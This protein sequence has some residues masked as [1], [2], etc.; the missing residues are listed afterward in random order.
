MLIS[1]M[2][3]NPVITADFILL[4]FENVLLLF[5]K[6]VTTL[7]IYTTIKQTFALQA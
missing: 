5:I 7:N 2:R 4:V 6:K 1:K 3:V